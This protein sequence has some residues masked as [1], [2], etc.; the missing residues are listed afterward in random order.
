MEEKKEEDELH[1]LELSKLSQF[2]DKNEFGQ[3]SLRYSENNSIHA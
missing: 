2:T 3:R 1:K